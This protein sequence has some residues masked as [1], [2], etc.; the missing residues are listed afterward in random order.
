MQASAFGRSCCFRGELRAPK[1]K[2]K[3]SDAVEGE[4]GAVR[5][6]TRHGVTTQWIAPRLVL[7]ASLV[8][9]TLVF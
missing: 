9:P 6:E 8:G 4:L 5:P 3:H 1:K 7:A 2:P